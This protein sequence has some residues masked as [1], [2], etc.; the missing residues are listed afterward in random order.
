[1]KNIL[2]LQEKD[3][4]LEE[5]S[6]HNIFITFLS[7]SIKIISSQSSLP[8]MKRGRA[9]FSSLKLNPGADMKLNLVLLID[10]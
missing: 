5:Q 4:R 1:M 10:L 9:S 7:L 8:C 3:G 6:Q 2:S